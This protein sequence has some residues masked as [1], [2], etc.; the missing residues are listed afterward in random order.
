[1]LR[2]SDGYGMAATK[3]HLS[4][5][6]GHYGLGGSDIVVY[7]KLKAMSCMLRAGFETI[8]YL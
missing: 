3:R 8:H 6:R 5:A 7:V 2:R 1:M 4:H